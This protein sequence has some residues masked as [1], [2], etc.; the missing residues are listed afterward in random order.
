M[1]SRCRQHMLMCSSPP[2]LDQP[3]LHVLQGVPA[4][5]AAA[6]APV[7]SAHSAWSGLPG[8]HCIPALLCRQLWGA[9][10]QAVGVLGKQAGGSGYSCEL[11]LPGLSVVPARPAD[12][13]PS[14]NMS[15]GVNNTSPVCQT[16]TVLLATVCDGLHDCLPGHESHVWHAD[17]GFG[18]LLWSA[19]VLVRPFRGFVRM[20]C[21][22][23]RLDWRGW[24]QESESLL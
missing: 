10:Q 22:C 7:P 24:W 19:R 8:H 11:L 6:A 23:C 2:P 14:N 21:C 13:K 9:G 4:V 16:T 5:C 20:R 15:A 17:G 3:Q 1:L 18:F 12:G